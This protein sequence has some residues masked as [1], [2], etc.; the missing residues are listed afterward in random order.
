MI[1]SLKVERPLKGIQSISIF[2]N[3]WS[4]DRRY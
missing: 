4:E 2:N 1:D 3:D